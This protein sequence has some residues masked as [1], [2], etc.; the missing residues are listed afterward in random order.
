M[1][2]LFTLIFLQTS[3]TAPLCSSCLCTPSHTFPYSPFSSDHG[4]VSCIWIRLPASFIT[5]SSWSFS[6]STFSSLSLSLF[7][8][9]WITPLTLLI[10]L[11]ISFS[12]LQALPDYI[13]IFYT[14]VMSYLD[15]LCHT[16][17]SPCHYISS[18]ATE[19]R[20]TAAEGFIIVINRLLLLLLPSL[21]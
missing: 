15:F 9:S 18:V 7:S 19:V 5:A 20:G 2:T 16:R 11:H 17:S 6:L 10:F 4:T 3:S 1:F 21:K 8:H 14:Q 12:S 13:G